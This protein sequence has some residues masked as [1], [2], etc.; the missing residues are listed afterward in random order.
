MRVDRQLQV[1]GCGAHFDGQHAFRNQ[2]PGAG[3]GDA[4]AEHAT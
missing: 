2:L 1:V 3:A 4:D